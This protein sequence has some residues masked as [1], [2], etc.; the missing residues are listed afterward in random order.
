M[1]RRP[2]TTNRVLHRSIAAFTTMERVESHRTFFV[3]AC[4]I[5]LVMPGILYY[6]P[7]YRFE[8]AREEAPEQ[9][10]VLRGSS[11]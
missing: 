1:P 8:V 11:G 5:E 4:F 7:V 3:S 2:T 9:A 10:Q 6:R